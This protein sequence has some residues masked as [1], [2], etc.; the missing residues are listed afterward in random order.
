M[1]VCVLSYVLCSACIEYFQLCV[2]A[3]SSVEE[4]IAEHWS[5]IIRYDPI[6]MHYGITGVTAN[7]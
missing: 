3:R 4:C 1:Y 2:H 5:S 6:V 7:S